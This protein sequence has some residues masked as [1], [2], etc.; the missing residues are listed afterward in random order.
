MIN[1]ERDQHM[2]LQQRIRVLVYSLSLAILATPALSRPTPSYSNPGFNGYRHTDRYVLSDRPRERYAIGNGSPRARGWRKRRKPTLATRGYRR[3]AE[4]RRSVRRKEAKR[5]AGRSVVSYT[6]STKTRYAVSTGRSASSKK[7]AASK[8]YAAAKAARIAKA[9][10]RHRR[11]VK[12]KPRVTAKPASNSI[13]VSEARRYLGTNPTGMARLWCARFMNMVLAR[14]GHRGTGSDLAKSFA[15]YGRRVGGPTV[16]AIAVLTRRGGGHVGVVSGVDKRG[17]PVLVSGNH[18]RR[19]AESTYP[20]HRVVAYVMPV[21]KD[22]GKLAEA[23]KL[24]VV[25]AQ[26]QI[27]Q[28]Q[29]Q[30]AEAQAMIAEAQTQVV[31]AQAQIRKPFV[32]E[33]MRIRRIATLPDW[34][35]VAAAQQSLPAEAGVIDLPHWRTVLASVRPNETAPAAKPVKAIKLPRLNLVRPPLVAAAE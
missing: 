30:I 8:R 32:D 5:R 14:T 19:V 25:E 9:Q 31:E 13:L 26:T 22:K 27:A 3:S 17:N 11:V 1:N 15:Q 21:T 24:Q 29:A 4:Y 6:I 28:E 10:M 7:Y 20:R 34:R 33:T 35:D 18:G 23:E 16:G 12:T 2:R